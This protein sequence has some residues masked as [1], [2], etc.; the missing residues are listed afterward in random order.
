MLD[1]AQWNNYSDRLIRGSVYDYKTECWIW[2]KSTV[3]E[4]PKF[5]YGDIRIGLKSLKT[6]RNA[7]AHRLSYEV[8]K[9]EIPKGLFVLH[10]C[11]N[12]RCINPDHLFLGTQKD[13][14]QD[15]NNKNRRNDAIGSKHPTAKLSEKQV[16]EI[17]ELHKKGILT[18]KLAKLFNTPYM[19][20]ASVIKRKSWKHI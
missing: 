3:G 10:K 12:T 9:G 11:D 19:T 18:S 16:L 6:Q 15:M 4:G 1:D 14:M 13:N 20:I 17:R 7:R 8:F 5:R 2:E